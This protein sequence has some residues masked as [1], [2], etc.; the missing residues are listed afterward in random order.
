MN[1]LPTH[2]STEI[3][4]TDVTKKI[5]NQEEVEEFKDNCI[6][7]NVEEFEGILLVILHF[8]IFYSI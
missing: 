4:E 3:K 7:E 8:S 2:A 1:H 6:Q 5:V